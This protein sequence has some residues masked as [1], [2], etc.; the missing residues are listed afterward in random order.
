MK[1]VAIVKVNWFNKHCEETDIVWETDPRINF[2]GGL[3]W[4]FYYD[5]ELKEIRNFIKSTNKWDEGSKYVI[6]EQNYESFDKDFAN[7]L[8]K[9]EKVKERRKKLSKEAKE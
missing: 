8:K 9:K 6:I 2:D 4:R 7:W 5:E 1:R 3:E